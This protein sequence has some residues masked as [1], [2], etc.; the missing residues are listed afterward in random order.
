[1]AN[2][3]KLT[4]SLNY[5]NGTAKYPFQ[6]GTINLP[7]TGKGY[8][9]LTQTFT[10]AEADIT[11]GTG[12]GT[13]LYAIVHNLEATTTGKTLNLGWKSSTGGIPVYGKIPPKALNFLA[14]GTSAM[15][16]RGKAASGS[17]QVMAVIFEA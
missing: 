12:V 8:M 3:L 2:E 11:V 5:A 6:P 10:T 1:M 13:P 9:V 16:L 15:V 14:Y 4:F 7:Q 17:L